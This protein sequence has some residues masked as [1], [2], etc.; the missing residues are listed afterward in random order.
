LTPSSAFTGRQLGVDVLRAARDDLAVDADHGLLGELVQ[1]VV[2][3]GARAGHE[4]RDAVVIAQIDEEDAAQVAPIVQPATQPDV[5]ADVRGAELA[6]GVG[7]VP[8][9]RRSSSLR[10]SGSSCHVKLPP[11]LP[12]GPRSLLRHYRPDAVAVFNTIFIKWSNAYW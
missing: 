11:S 5:G 1:R 8:M 6:A 2:R 7:P 10:G 12:A 3:L 4:L 9:H